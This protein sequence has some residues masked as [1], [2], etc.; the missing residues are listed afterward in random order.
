MEEDKLKLKRAGIIRVRFAP[1]PTGFLHIGGTRT[2]LF[3][4]VF[5]KKQKGV[6]IL[7]IED[8]DLERSKAEFEEDIKE[9]LKWLGLNWDEFYKQSE[10]LEIYK[11]YLEK[12][13][14]NDKAYYCFCSEEELEAHRQY[15]LSIG[16]PPIYSGKCANLSEETVKKYLKEGKSFIIRFRTPGKKIAF[17]DLVREKVEFDGGLIGDFVIAKS[18]SLP[19]YNLAATIDD[20]EMKISHVIRGEEHISNTPKQLILQE[21][22]GLPHPKYGHLPLILAPDRSKLS[23]RQGAVSIKEFR[24][25]GY[26]PEALINYMAFLGWNPGTEREIY[27]LASLT[28]DFSLDRI[29]KGGAIFNVGKLDWINGFYIRQKSPERLT[30]LCI[31]F[32]IKAKLIERVGDNPGNPSPEELK[33]FEEKPQFKI[34]ETGEPLKIGELLEI[35]I[36]YQ[37]RIKK[38]SD[39]AADCDFFFK[40]ELSYNKDLLK[41]QEMSNEE[42][43]NSLDRVG[44]VLSKVENVNWTKENLKEALMPEAEKMEN[45][46]YLLWPLRVALT[47]K[48]GSAGPF[49]IATILGKD[50]TLNRIGKAKKLINM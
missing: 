6:F 24:E 34:R 2:A 39:I 37:T 15:L 47:G 18:L 14:K 9:N 42:V 12:L 8:T 1:S 22:L 27:S 45:R 5:A 43:H 44:E 23:K 36:L 11:D 4:Y 32:L 13:L 46:G 35:I 16:K 48:Q 19:L 30:E 31:P 20:F 50:K 33:L 3:N 7:R 26:L 38:L 40:E 49:E 28:K 25:L 29:Q 41:W 10:R 21:A 17:H